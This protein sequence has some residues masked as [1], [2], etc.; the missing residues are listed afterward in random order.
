ML[1]ETVWY[2]KSQNIRRVYNS[3][4]APYIMIRGIMNFLKCD[5]QLV[6][7]IWV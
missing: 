4:T 3:A 7:V 6:T 5:I 1:K 2:N